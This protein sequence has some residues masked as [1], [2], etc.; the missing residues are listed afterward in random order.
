[1]PQP[2][3]LQRFDAVTAAW[4]S[5]K[6]I[7]VERRRPSR[8]RPISFTKPTLR[9]F[10]SRE[11]LMVGGGSV[12][13]M[14]DQTFVLVAEDEELVRLVI[15]QALRDE[16]FEVMEVEHAA[17]ALIVLESQARRIHVLFT[18]IQMPGT[19]D[20]LALAHH[21]SKHWPWIGLLITS[22]RPRPDRPAFPEESRFLAKPYQHRH[23]IH[24]IRE[25]AAA[26]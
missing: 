14:P 8:R 1:L 17:A 11:R 12:A 4:H 18:D 9:N 10:A 13:I 5:L 7:V 23:V 21:T 20:G 2:I 16:G 26:A 22:A 24:H 25:L 6:V 19:I 15:V 3:P